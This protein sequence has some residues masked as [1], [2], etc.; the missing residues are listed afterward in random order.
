MPRGPASVPVSAPRFGWVRICLALVV[1]T[2]A[3]VGATAEVQT[4][5]DVTLAL[6]Y[7]S[8][9]LRI[10]GDGSNAAFADAR[11]DGGLTVGSSRATQFF[12]RGGL[13]RRAHGGASN[14]D[15]WGFGVRAGVSTRPPA[16]Q[17]RGPLS[18]SA[19]GAYGESRSTFT[20]RRTGGAYEVEVEG[21]GGAPSTVAVPDR[22]DSRTIGAFFNLRWRPAARTRVSLDLQLDRADFLKDYSDAGLAPLDYR[23]LSVEPGVQYRVNDLV[24]LGAYV[25]LTHLDYD[26]Q[27]A[28]GSDGMEVAGTRRRYRYAEHRLAVRVTPRR[29]LRIDFGARGGNR[30]DRYAGYYDYG[31]RVTYMAFDQ[32]VSAAD[33]LQVFASLT[34]LDYDRATLQTADDEQVLL[35]SRVRR[36]IGRYDRALRADLGVFV[37]VGSQHTGSPDPVFTHDREWMLTGI[38]FRR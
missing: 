24:V 37:E 17:G 2:G 20:D 19:G 7:D 11:V 28:V 4:D 5:L 12:A 22:F 14:A 10:S 15:T 16:L 36:L 8:N 26:E 35:G 27:P 13:A 38:R 6:G 21:P 29:D 32:K 31:S 33:R 23:T 25:V 9:P 30:S 34:R 18:L 1:L 3:G